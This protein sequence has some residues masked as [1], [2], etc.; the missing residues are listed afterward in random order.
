[1]FGKNIP[2]AQFSNFKIGGP[3]AYFFQAKDS[4]SVIAAVTEA[5]KLDLPIFILGGAT[6]L[7]ISDEGFPGL[8]LQPVLKNIHRDGNNIIVGAGAS[9]KELLDFTISEKLSGLEWAGGLPGSVGGAIFGNAGAFGGE[10]KDSLVNVTSIDLAADSLQVHVR[11]NSE[12]EFNYRSSIFKTGRSFGTNEV[13]LE[14]TFA[15][16]TGEQKEIERL[17]EEK[18]EYRK[19]RQ[20]LEYPNI[21]SIFKNIPIDKISQEVLEM[22]KHKI[23]TDPFP[24]LP[25]A[26]LADAAGLKKRS[27]GGAQVSEKH[28]NFII[29]TG[30]ATARDVRELIQIFRQELKERFGVELEQ[31]VIDL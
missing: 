3:A 5:R 4:A 2:L 6:N 1:M 18:R 12:C 21:G 14:A 27:V 19:N 25:N 15:L 10:I 23:K 11:S 17:I 28:P 26:V 8:I 9:I 20:P 24:V 30:N 16:T 22:F 31:E 29:N 13:I 7:L